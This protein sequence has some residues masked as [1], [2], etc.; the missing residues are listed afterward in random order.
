MSAEGMDVHARAIKAMALRAQSKTWDD[1]AKEAGY[2]SRGVAYQAV[3]RFMAK[4]ARETTDMLVQFE[5]E[6]LR[7]IEESL[8]PKATRSGKA[9]TK[10]VAA[11]LRV[12]E[13][14]SKLMG[15]D[16]YERR[17]IE[18]AERQHGLEQS[19]AQIVYDVMNR[20]FARLDLSPAQAAM[21]PTLV[22]EEI[23]RVTLE[24]TE[25]ESEVIDSEA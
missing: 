25:L 12:M 13:R 17:S 15:L 5:L 11:E 9:Q 8:L 24:L 1:V 2:S 20:I 10:Y 23:G 21:L 22:P 4:Q 18:L 19:Q 6:K 7:A 14:R 3:K 16:D